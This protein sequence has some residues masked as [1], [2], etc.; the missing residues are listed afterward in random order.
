MKD[1][2]IQRVA[3]IAKSDQEKAAMALA[4]ATEKSQQAKDQSDQLKS[5]RTDYEQHFDDMSKEGTDARTVGEY[6]K[7]LGNLDEA[8]GV[9]DAQVEQTHNRVGE[10]QANWMAQRARQKALEQLADIQA[11]RSHSLAERREQKALDEIS[12]NARTD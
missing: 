9:Q 6:R 12:A 10:S 11:Q 3:S 8:I 5:Y 4:R 7:F 1:K 2:T